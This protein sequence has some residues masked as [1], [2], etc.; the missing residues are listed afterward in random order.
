MK[1][2]GLAVWAAA[3]PLNK[4]TDEQVP[5][6][7][8]TVDLALPLEPGTIGLNLQH[9]PTPC[10]D[11]IACIGCNTGDTGRYSEPYFEFG[12]IGPIL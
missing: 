2:A 12:I 9:R 1:V 5:L 4:L 7:I 10:I 6:F 11:C 8:W 3:L